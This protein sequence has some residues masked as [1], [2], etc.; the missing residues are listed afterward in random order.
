MKTFITSLIITIVFIGGFYEYTK[1]VVAP[2][3]K[4]SYRLKKENHTLV[5]MIENLKKET[6]KQSK[7]SK[8]QESIDISGELKDIGGVNVSEENKKI[9][10]TLPGKKLFPPGSVEISKEGIVL[11]REIGNIIKDMKDMD[12]E[13]DGHTDNTKISGS[14][15]NKY[16][17]NWD[18][19]AKRA[20]N[21]VRFLIEEVGIE[22]ARLCAVAYSQYRPIADNSTSRGR[23]KNRRIVIMLKPRG[24]K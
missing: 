10:I 2:L 23:D 4:V 16:P 24:K 15:R 9:S 22:P 3:K 21:I 18:L 20:V 13:I 19:S 8:S 5:S 14:L 7:L 6:G 11:L 1:K 12:I 17:T